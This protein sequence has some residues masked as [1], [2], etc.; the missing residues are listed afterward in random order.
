MAAPERRIL[1]KPQNFDQLFPGRFLKH[2]LLGGR[3]VTVTIAAVDREVLEGDKGD[4]EA[5]ILSFKESP[6]M[7]VVCKTNG[8]C[9]RGMFGPRVQEWVGKRVTLY[10]D[11]S[12]RFGSETVGGVR[13]RGSPDIASAVDVSIKLKKRRAFTMTMA[14]TGTGK[15]APSTAMHDPNAQPPAGA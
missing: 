8:L 5:T 1:A 7:L 14:V 6:K 15:V 13:L 12:I 9:L 10:A 2:G 4:E 3:D 11:E